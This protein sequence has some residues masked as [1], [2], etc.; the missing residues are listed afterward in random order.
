MMK[1]PS[2]PSCLFSANDEAWVG[3]TWNL[4]P[5]EPL[6]WLIDCCVACGILVPWPRIKLGP[7]AVRVRSP[8]HRTT[9]EFPQPIPTAALF[10]MRKFAHSLFVS[11]PLSVFSAPVAMFLQNYFTV[12]FLQR[13]TCLVS[14]W[15]DLEREVSFAQEQER[16]SWC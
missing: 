3:L 15:S 11:C 16:W 1:F 5:T 10:M 12:I 8:K 4:L 13:I 9:R 2:G 14:L 7:T 6:Y